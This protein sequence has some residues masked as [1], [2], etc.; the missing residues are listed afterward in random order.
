MLWDEGDDRFEFNKNLHSTG[1]I[2]SAAGISEFYGAQVNAGGLK[3]QGGGTYSDPGSQMYL[4]A[5]AS[6]HG[7]LAVYDMYFYTGSNNS[8]TVQAL[9][10]TNTGDVHLKDNAVLQFGNS[11]HYIQG[12]ASQGGGD[13]KIRSS[14]DLQLYSRY[15]RFQDDVGSA[16]EY[17][18]IA[19]NGS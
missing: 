16:G 9:K 15:V 8:R 10:L 5:D 6:G 13:I 3:V 19:H 12:G 14:D 7:Y 2:I 18:R 17:A 11:S 4:Y 1:N